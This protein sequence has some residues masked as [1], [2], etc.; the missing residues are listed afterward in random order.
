V[1]GLKDRQKPVDCQMIEPHTGII[2]KVGNS[3]KIR[4]GQ[5]AYRIE[6]SGSL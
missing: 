6:I 3:G 4:L 2:L 1:S 5:A